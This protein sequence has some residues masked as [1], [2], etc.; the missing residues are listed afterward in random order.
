M[1]E[2]VQ[3]SW[4]YYRR[5][6]EKRGVTVTDLG[7]PEVKPSPPD[8]GLTSQ[9]MS[10]ITGTVNST[11]KSNPTWDE[12]WG[13]RTKGPA[14][15]LKNS[16]NNSHSTHPDLGFLPIQINSLQSQFSTIP[17]VSSQQ[18]AVSCAPVDI[19]WPPRASSGVTPQ[20]GDTEKQL[21]TTTSSTSSFDG[22]DPFAD[23]PPRPSGSVNGAGN[24]NNG[25]I[26]Q[27]TNK[28]G[29]S[30]IWNAPNSMG[31]QTNNSISWA[32][33]TQTSIQQIGQSQGNLTLASGSLATGIF[34]PQSSIGF[35]KQSRGTPASSGHID[36]KSTD[37][38]SIFASSKNELSTPRLAPPPST[39]VGRGRGRGRGAS[40]ASRSSH[41]KSPSEQPPILDLL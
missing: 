20:L 22:K 11:A 41:A 2:L 15:S 7:I 28:Y 30:P 8:N 29:S 36:K 25:T 13:P 10:K 37:L 12:D 32:F 18:T 26:G 24:S 40:S 1:I 27:P 5:I 19:E 17:A 3:P 4:F 34:N 9:A 39:A 6:E 38:G 21:N 31:L 14:S 23:W 33:D 35:L 16:T